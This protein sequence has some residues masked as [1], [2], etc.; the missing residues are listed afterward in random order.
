MITASALAPLD[1][2]RVILARLKVFSPAA[3][4]AWYGLSKTREPSG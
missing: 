3:L 4:D 2:A 1:F